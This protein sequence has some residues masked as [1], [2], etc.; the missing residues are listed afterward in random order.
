MN[1]FLVLVMMVILSPLSMASESRM[2]SSQPYQMCTLDGKVIMVQANMC[3]AMG[4]RLG[5]Q[6]EK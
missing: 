3:Y 4:G 5:G 6:V 2:P 1:K